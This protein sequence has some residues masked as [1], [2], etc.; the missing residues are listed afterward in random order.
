MF[1][2]LTAQRH[3]KGQQCKDFAVFNGQVRANIKA[4]LAPFAGK[5][6]N[7]RRTLRAL[8][9]ELSWRPPFNLDFI[10]ARGVYT[11]LSTVTPYIQRPSRAGFLHALA[12]QQG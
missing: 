3:L 6:R 2:A 4:N 10:P 1:L 12:S 7:F 5:V 11:I 9:S 8:V